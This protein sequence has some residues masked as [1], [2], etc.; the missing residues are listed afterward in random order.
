ME[1]KSECNHIDCSDVCID[2]GRS[3]DK[4]LIVVPI[5]TEDQ[6]EAMAGS[7]CDINEKTILIND[8][9]DVYR[10]DGSPILHFRRNAIP[11]NLCDDAFSNLRL[12]GI[13][14]KYNTNRGIS[15]GHFNVEEFL[16]N[17]KNVKAED[18]K[19]QKG[20]YMAYYG[21]TKLANAA[22]SSIV[23]YFDAPN[24]MKPQEGKC[25][26]TSFTAKY[27]DQFNAS[28]PFIRYADQLFSKIEPER[29]QTQLNRAKMSKGCIE[30]TC[31][32]TM[33]VNYNWRSALHQDA[34]DYRMGFGAFA[35]TENINTNSNSN[36][37]STTSSSPPVKKKRK[38]ESNSVESNSVE[39]NSVESKNISL[40]SRFQGC[41]LMFPRYNVA[42]DCRHGDFLLF[43]SHEW[44]C[45]NKADFSNGGERLSFVMYLRVSMLSSC[46]DTP[47][48]HIHQLKKYKMYFPQIDNISN[49]NYIPSN[50]SFKSK[51]F[52]IL[53]GSHWLDIGA[54]IGHFAMW[55]LSLGAKHVTCIE[56]DE[57]NK[58]TIVYNSFLNVWEQNVTV[59]KELIEDIDHWI[60]PNI[61]A[62][63]IDNPLCC[64]SEMI[65]KCKK[66]DQITHLVIVIADSEN[67]GI[68]SAI[69]PFFKH[70]SIENGVLYA[71]K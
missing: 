58:E 19:I 22:A 30:G 18:I 17:H 34:G 39:S 35:V 60:S 2:I 48:H 14:G 66:W 51:N 11:Q 29:Y 36:T 63:K 7:Y 1:V 67:N 69:N 9:C 26:L 68:I 47:S 70:I 40:R 55:A 27:S 59:K 52:K 43:D 50:P 32:S 37:T 21:K 25:R 71:K 56:P 10:E 61:T 62:V 20:G 49:T 45:N 5:Y 4:R 54:G 53:P 23:G 64:N 24:R 15:G 28:L 8:D 41:E 57:K 38:V 65:K 16:K 44:H 46:Q 31:F 6:L 42:V 33:S 12:A 3:I 13:K